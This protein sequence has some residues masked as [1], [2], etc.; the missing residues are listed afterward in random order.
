M[1]VRKI[2]GRPTVRY[3]NTL[4]FDHEHKETIR[5]VP[6]FV[7]NTVAVA[8]RGGVVWAIQVS[9]DTEN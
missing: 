5:N 6:Y 9:K 2:L 7:S 3:S 4:I 8:L 1:Q